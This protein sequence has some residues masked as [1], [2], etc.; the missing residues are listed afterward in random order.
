LRNGTDGFTI[1]EVGIY[2]PLAQTPFLY[3]DE[4]I[5]W[6]NGTSEVPSHERL[7]LEDCGHSEDLV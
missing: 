6:P 4:G 2:D 7:I 3:I 5:L 1:K